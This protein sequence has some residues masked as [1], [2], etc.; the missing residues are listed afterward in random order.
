MHAQGSSQYL[1]KGGTMVQKKEFG[2]YS[3]TNLGLNNAMPL[4]VYVT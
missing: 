4:D 3:K 1:E 2:F